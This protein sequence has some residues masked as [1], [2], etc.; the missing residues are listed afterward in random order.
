MHAL[1]SVS[2]AACW[3]RADGSIFYVNDMTCQT[4][5]YTREELLRMSVQDLV[6]AYTPE[7][8]AVGLQRLRETGSMAIELFYRSKDGHIH[9][10]EGRASLVVFDGE[11]FNCAFLS[12]ITEKKQAELERRCLAEVV[13]AREAQLRSIFENTIEGILQ[14]EHGGRIIAANP[15]MAAILGYESA[16]ELMD[17]LTHFCELFYVTEHADRFRQLLQ[18]ESQALGFETQARRKDGSAAW[19]V[20]NARAVRDEDGKIL[21]VDGTVM[22]LSERKRME[23]D[24]YRAQRLDSLGRLVGGITHD[25]RNILSPVLMTPVLLRE[26]LSDPEE[27]KLLDGLESSVRRGVDML[28]QLLTFS[29]GTDG[30]LRK[31]S[32]V[33]LVRGMLPVLE[34]TFPKNITIT[35]SLRDGLPPVLGD[36]TQLE[37]VVMNL[38]V[39]A[40]D[41]MPGGGELSL[42]LELAE[43]DQLLAGLSPSAQPGPHVVLRITDTGTGIHPDDLASIFN[44]FFTTKEIGKGTGLG[45]STVIGILKSHRGIVKPDS[46]LGQGTCFSVY[47]PVAGPEQDGQDLQDENR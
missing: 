20:I 33:D 25:L 8:Y 19:V 36:A 5:G 7:L 37:Q 38:C 6:P 1:E 30:A 28:N 18:K 24:L 40:R 41:A 4:T 45:L 10:A 13:R 2:V 42:I 23:A 22:D 34:A 35:A 17:A 27:L 9:P 16:Q 44:P 12:D 39:N 43:V 21:H 3:S 15:S 26:S 29:R 14:I 47:L 31:L 11:E 46:V 32:L